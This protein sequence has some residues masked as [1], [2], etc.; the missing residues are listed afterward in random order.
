MI[1]D[2]RTGTEGPRT[3]PGLMGRDYY[4]ETVWRQECATVFRNSWFCV[5]RTEEVDAAGDYISREVAG[6]SVIAVRGKDGAVERGP[7]ASES[8]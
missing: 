1:D 3:F 7:L 8:K 2:V 6:T 5:G 4:G